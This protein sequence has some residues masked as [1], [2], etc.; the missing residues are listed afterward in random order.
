VAHVQSVRATL[1]RRRGVRAR[2][3]VLEDICGPPG[4]RP[5]SRYGNGGARERLAVANHCV[6]ALSIEEAQLSM[7]RR[8]GASEE[9]ILVVQGNLA[10]T[11]ASNRRFEE[12]QE[13]ERDVYSGRMK[14]NGEA[15]KNTLLAAN[16]YAL[17][18][19]KQK[20]YEEA[21]LLMQKCLPAARRLL[22]E[23]D[24]IMLRNRL[25]I[26]RRRSTRTT[27]PRSK[28]SAKP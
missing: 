7:L 2:V 17:S 14:L 21:K 4:D 18:L 26:T 9:S 25:Y 24:E 8:L 12:A 22:G 13:I 1:S 15:H 19:C 10:C 23:S 3:G 28:I 27:A 16:N 5:A 11:Y 20:A 6:D